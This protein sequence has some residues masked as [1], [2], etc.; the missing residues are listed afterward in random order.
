MGLFDNTCM[1]TGV[2]LKPVPTTAIILRREPSGAEHPIS[3]AIPGTHDRLGGVD[4]VTEGPALE[5]LVNYFV[6][7]AREQRFGT[8]GRAEMVAIV[9]N[10]YSLDY[11]LEHIFHALTDSNIDVS[12]SVEPSVL[13]DGNQITSALMATSVW[14]AL[15]ASSSVD[16]LG[17][18]PVDVSEALSAYPDLARI[19]GTHL[20]QFTEELHELHAV[21][22]SLAGRGL[23]WASLHTPDQRFPSEGSQHW[24]HEIVHWLA[25]A[26]EVYRDDPPVLAAL[27]IY[28]A[29]CDAYDETIFAPTKDK[30]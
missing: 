29:E 4:G 12:G 3:F 20:G 27:D 28:R 7:A 23:K 17:A 21:G 8:I 14:N 9:N 13:L 10:E 2:S 26:R 24:D 18:S 6:A 5:A 11:T 30:D 22:R 19:Y 16:G 15:A 25:H 1:V